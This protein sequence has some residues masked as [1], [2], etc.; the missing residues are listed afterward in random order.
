MRYLTLGEVLE[1]YQRVM[2]MSGGAQGIR[3]LEALQSSMAQPR[4]TF[5]GQELYVGVIEKAAALGL[6]L[7][8]NHPFVDGNKRVG[9]AA[10]E[11]FLVLNG[12]EVQADPKEQEE[13]ILKVATGEMSRSEFVM[14]LRAHVLICGQQG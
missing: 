8:K 14:W 2:E 7:I 9:H 6:S 1:L 13:V 5:G 10:M 4:M 12:Y 11:T 3:D